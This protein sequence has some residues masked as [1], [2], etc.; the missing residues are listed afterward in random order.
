VSK[1]KSL[2]EILDD[3]REARFD[4]LKG[5]AESFE[6]EVKGGPYVL[7]SERQKHELAKDVSALA[8]AMGG[9]I[10]IG[11]RTERD[12]QL[13]G[14]RIE[15]CRPFEHGL[16]DLNQYRNVL[17]DWIYPP[18]QNLQIEWFPSNN[19]D[20]GVVAIRVPTE[21]TD[22]SPYVVCKTIDLDGKI[23][24]NLIGYYQRVQDR[25][26]ARTPQLLRANLKDG[27][28]FGELNTRLD[29]LEQSIALLAATVGT[30][31]TQQ[32]TQESS[33][34]SQEEVEDRI[35]EA[36][37]AVEREGLPSIILSANS[38]TRCDFEGLFESR[39]EGIVR[40]FE[41]PPTLRDQ[42]FVICVY[43]ASSIIRARLRRCVAPENEL[44]DLWKDGCLIAVGPGDGGLLGWM[45]NRSDGALP[46]RNFILTEVVLNFLNLAMKVFRYATPLAMRLPPGLTQTVKTLLAVR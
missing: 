1:Q 16:C 7:S 28:R 23:N 30:L 3:L 21:A 11:F 31:I 43:R 27:S 6:V 15:E 38:T 4:A 34:I 42:G 32:P 35:H 19:V 17:N 8:N 36:V 37:V 39:S 24:G 29:N 14:E 10:L 25:V 12:P 2:S 44:L 26:I 13:L 22:G 5:V 33:G 20:K 45:L 18:I 40:L 46:I 41:N 9:V